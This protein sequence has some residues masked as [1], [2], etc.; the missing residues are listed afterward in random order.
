[1]FN[2][3]G[4][5][6]RFLQVNF[7]QTISHEA[8]TA[9]A[10]YI[11][12]GVL[13]LSSHLLS[14]L[15]QMALQLGMKELEMLCAAHLSPQ[16]LASMTVKNDPG[17]RPPSPFDSI[18]IVNFKTDDDI[19]SQELQSTSTQSR[20][21]TKKMLSSSIYQRLVIS[22]PEVMLS[23]EDNKHSLCLSPSLDESLQYIDNPNNKFDEISNLPADIPDTCI[24]SL[25]FES[26]AEKQISISNIKTEPINIDDDDSCEQAESYPH[27]APTASPADVLTTNYSS[28]VNQLQEQR[29]MGSTSHS[30][31]K[32]KSRSS[33]NRIKYSSEDEVHDTGWQDVSFTIKKSKDFDQQPSSDKDNLDTDSQPFPVELISVVRSR[34]SSLKSAPD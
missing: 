8:L 27:N 9:F 11:Y 1:M 10:E 23:K 28:L 18:Q 3:S 34:K 16:D 24:D 22:S 5:S 12:N 17:E 30:S 21:S 31:Q 26:S 15:Q 13:D 19:F 33:V 32:R 7:P 2:S 20:P 25:G 29:L 6:N 4:Q 14:Q